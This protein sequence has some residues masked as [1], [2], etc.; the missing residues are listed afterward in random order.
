MAKYQIALTPVDKFFFGGDITFKAEGRDELNEDF[1]SYIIQSGK[2]PQQTSLLGMLRFLILRNDPDCFR[3][4][5]ITDK[6][7][8]AGLIGPESFAVNSSEAAPGKPKDFGVIRSISRCRVQVV[9]HKGVSSL[10]FKPLYRKS[11]SWTDQEVYLN[12]HPVVMPVLDYSPKEGLKSVLSDGVREYGLDEV[13]EEDRRIGINR[14]V[15]T[16]KTDDGALFK[17][18]SYR[19]KKAEGRSFRFSFEAEVDKVNLAAY[20]GQLVSVGGDN[21]WF[22][23]EVEESDSKAASASAGNVQMVTLLSPAFIPRKALLRTRFGITSLVS[24]RFLKT[25]VAQTGEYSILNKNMLR[26]KKYKL[27][28]AGSQFFFKDAAQKAEFISILEAQEDF[29]QIGYNEYQ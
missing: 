26:S 24:F 20:S 22:V 13:F 4:G 23:L 17:Q 11:I 5:R 10:D 21:S 28:A 9:T 2:F 19:F 12:D 14:D 7:K 1:Q 25:S 6:A 15:S 18:I 29:R 27:Y 8:A 3:D 16:G